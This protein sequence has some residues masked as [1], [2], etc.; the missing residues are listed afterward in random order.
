LHTNPDEVFYV[1][2]AENNHPDVT[3]PISLFIIKLEKRHRFR[4]AIKTILA[5]NV[6]EEKITLS[7]SGDFGGNGDDIG[8]QWFYREENGTVAP[9]PPASPWRVFLD[10]TGQNGLGQSMIDFEG[11]GGLLL[12]DNL[13]FVRYRHKNDLLAG[14]PHGVNWAGTEWEIFGQPSAVLDRAGNPVR[15]EDG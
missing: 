14:N 8:Y 3:G 1:T 7:H 6:F 2:L 10:R 12:A 9:L 15:G 11:T 4:G 13:F 5:D